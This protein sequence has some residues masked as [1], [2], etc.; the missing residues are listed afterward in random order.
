MIFYRFEQA[1]ELFGS[2]F[3]QQTRLGESAGSCRTIR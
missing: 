3:W 2:V 1:G